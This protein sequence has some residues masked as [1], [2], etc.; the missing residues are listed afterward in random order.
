MNVYLFIPFSTFLSFH[1]EKIIINVIFLRNFILHLFFYFVIEV[2][3][4]IEILCGHYGYS[5]MFCVPHQG[6]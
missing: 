2:I 6:I 4:A 3:D 5:S 1:L